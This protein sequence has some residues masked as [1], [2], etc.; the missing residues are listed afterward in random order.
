MSNSRWLIAVLAAMLLGTLG[1]QPAEIPMI[2]IAGDVPK[3]G[4]WSIDRIRQSLTLDKISFQ[5]R[6]GK[7]HTGDGV[8][9]V[10][11]LNGAG[12]DT[13]FK[14]NP[15]ADPK[16]KNY[17]LRL[18]VL[19]KGTDGYTVAFSLAELLANIGDR[20]VSLIIDEDGQP[21][22]SRDAPARLIVPDDKIPA[23][24]VHAVS[25]IRVIDPTAPATQPDN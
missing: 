22:S 20:Q 13:N 16:M 7:S 5:T 24:W 19:V 21:L 23:R 17:S 2:H 14:M 15:T 10:Q 6:D 9:L 8:S 1:A 11:L 18:I 25:E 3:R 12:L 4:D